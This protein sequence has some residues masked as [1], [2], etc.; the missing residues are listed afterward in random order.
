LLEVY[1]V[2]LY[3]RSYKKEMELVFKED[4]QIEGEGC[5]AKCR[6]KGSCMNSPY[7]ELV[8]NFVGLL[9][10]F[11][12]ISRTFLDNEDPKEVVKWMLVSIGINVGYLVEMM[13]YFSF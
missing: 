13:I 3:E 9:Q 11:T 5:C 6:R 4:K 1:E 10:T 2:W 7:Y 8:M 12:I